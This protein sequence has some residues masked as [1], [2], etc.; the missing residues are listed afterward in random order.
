MAPA[1]NTLRP[2][3]PSLAD[4]ER[5]RREL[6]GWQAAHRAPSTKSPAEPLGD[7]AADEDPVLEEVNRLAEHLES[8]QAL[9]DLQEAEAP[10]P[11]LTAPEPPALAEPALY[12][13]AILLQFL[14]AFGNLLGPALHCTVGAT[15]HGL[16]LFVV[17]VGESS[18]ARKGTSWRQI[19]SL[20]TASVLHMLGQPTGQ[21]SPLL[22]C[23]WDG[24]DLSATNGS[25]LLHAT[26]AHLSIVAHIT[27]SELAQHLIRTESHNG[28]ANRCLWTSVR[29]GQSLPEGGSLL[30][31][32]LS[33]LARELRRTLNWAQSQTEILFRRT[34]AARELWT[35]RYPAL[36][37]GRLDAYGAATSRAEA[38]RYSQESEK[39]VHLGRI[40][41]D[42]N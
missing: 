31:D 34:E 30:P 42:G 4:I 24:G 10:G 12:G 40:F 29:R 6:L 16:N 41:L 23:A 20:F 39:M 18:K 14:A 32:Q 8:L 19:A 7:P 37:H 25:Q 2:S 11:S 38:R 27:E 35:N 5:R 9:E 15:R 36:S 21:L 33:A 1:N 13:L 26:S 28:F 3:I 17:L 22:R